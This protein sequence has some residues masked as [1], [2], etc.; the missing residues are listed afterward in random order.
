[1]SEKQEP[2]RRDFLSRQAALGALPATLQAAQN[3]L[4][5]FVPKASSR[6]LGANDRINVGFIG[7]GMQ[8][9]SL[10]R[11]AFFARKE[12]RNDFEFA[13]V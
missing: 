6:P 8:F 4:P 1:V 5:K 13:A 3:R 11:R 7:N 2:S 10:L 12:A 9:H